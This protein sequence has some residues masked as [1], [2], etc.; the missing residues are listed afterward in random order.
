MKAVVKTKPGKGFIEL[1]EVD[2]PKIG[3]RD[4][5]I[6]VKAAGICGT[7]LHIREDTF[8]NIP[9]VIVGHE[10]SGEIVEVGKDV[11]TYQPGDRVV[12]EPHRGG[13]GVCPSCLT[14][15]VEVCSRKKAIGYKVDGCFA[16][17]VDLPITSLHRIPEHVTFEQA[18]LSEPLAVNV[19]GVLERARVAPE[20][21]VVVLGCGPIGLLGAA[22]AKAAGARAVMI[23]GTDRDEHERLRVAQEMGIDYTVNVQ[24][25]DLKQRVDD[26]TNGAGADLVVEASGAEPAIRQAFDI[27]KIDGRVA[28][29]GITGRQQIALNWDVALKKAAHLIYSF[30]S[31]WTSWERTVS[32]LG[33]GKI[34]V[35][36]M[37]SRKMPLDDWEAAFDLL[38]RQEAIKILLMP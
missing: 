17:Y 37:I 6:R 23:T 21:F 16:E 9:P 31:N 15:Q 27:L 19:K 26:L 1:R 30:S 33:S 20:D 13:C 34:N 10:F 2:T 5:L 35:E 4:V 18:A 3:D 28:A 24:K 22:A 7:D 25:E 8:I 29:V 38:Q 36:P 32:L 12:A 14:G 11:S